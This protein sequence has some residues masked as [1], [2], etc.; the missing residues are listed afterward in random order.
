MKV[1]CIRILPGS[2]GWDVSVEHL[3]GDRKMPSIAFRSGFVYVPETM[4]TKKAFS[5]LRTKMVKEHLTEI[6][7]LTKSLKKLRALKSPEKEG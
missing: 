6:A 7:R 1:K 2:S 4:P 5:D 3:S